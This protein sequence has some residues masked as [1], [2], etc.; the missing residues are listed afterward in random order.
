MKKKFLILFNNPYKNKDI[1]TQD[2]KKLKKNFNDV[3]LYNFFEKRFVINVFNE[4]KLNLIHKNYQTKKIKINLEKIYSIN[5]FLKKIKKK[6]KNKQFYISTFVLNNSIEEDIIFYELSK[7]YKMQYLKPERSFI[8]NRYILSKNLYKQHYNIKKK[9]KISKKQIDTLKVN[10]ILAMD[11]YRKFILKRN[12]KSNFNFFNKF[13]IYILS[14]IFKFKINKQ[15]KKYALMLLGNS[16]NLNA[17]AAAKEFKIFVN[18]FLSN[19]DYQLVFLIHP[20][21]SILKYLMWHIKNMKIFFN[22]KRITFIQK[23]KSIVKIISDSEF[24]FHLTSSASAQ[25]L[26]FDKRIL[27]LGKNLIYLNYLNNLVTNINYNNFNFL[28]RKINRL[29][30]YKLNK[31]LQKHLIEYFLYLI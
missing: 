2:I 1:N 7:I 20:N 24:V 4:K 6:F 22:S 3:I 23:P 8:K 5:F 21:T 31:F 16:L 13:L 11:N 25:A 17:F 10:Y 14:L 27:C 26:M 28:K 29:E 19:F 15:P 9:I 30:I 18:K 12:S